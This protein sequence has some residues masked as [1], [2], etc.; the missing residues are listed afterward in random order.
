LEVSADKLRNEVELKFAYQ[1]EGVPFLAQQL[2]PYMKFGKEG[3]PLCFHGCVY[4]GGTCILIPKHS[5]AIVALETW[6]GGPVR[7]QAGR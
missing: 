4:I 7:R 5:L 1:R 6:A 3:L 2:V